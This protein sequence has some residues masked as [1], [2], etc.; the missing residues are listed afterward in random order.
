MAYA[1]TYMRSILGS[2]PFLVKLYAL[3]FCRYLF[4][5]PPPPPP[6]PPRIF[7]AGDPFLRASGCFCDIFLVLLIYFCVF[8]LFHIK[9]LHRIVEQQVAI[10]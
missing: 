3:F 4:L 7:H 2:I 1:V 9:K 6:P 8:L 10:K 5:A